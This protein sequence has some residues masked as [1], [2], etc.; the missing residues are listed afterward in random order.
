MP[1]GIEEGAALAVALEDRAPGRPRYLASSLSSG[2]FL[3]RE[4]LPSRCL[5]SLPQRLL[6]TAV[7]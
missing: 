3:G 4:V 6:S 7:H 5:S 2:D 1:F